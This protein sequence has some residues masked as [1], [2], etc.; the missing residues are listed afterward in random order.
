[1]IN[2]DSNSNTSPTLNSDGPF[3]QNPTDE[4]EYDP[5]KRR[6]IDTVKAF[7]GGRYREKDLKS[8][9]PIVVEKEEDNST[10]E[11]DEENKKSS[12]GQFP[13]KLNKYW[14]EKLREPFW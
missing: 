7:F 4:F 8:P 13:S 14:D 10:L 1:M 5:H 9:K 12:L 3:L 2:T 11:I 6:K